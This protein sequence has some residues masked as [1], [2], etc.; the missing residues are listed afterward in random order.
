MPAT[1]EQARTDCGDPEVSLRSSTDASPH[2]APPRLCQHCENPIIFDSAWSEEWIHDGSEVVWCPGNRT[3]AA[4]KPED[5][6][7]RT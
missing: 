5:D 4:P 2:R 7:F 6:P 1:P 3:T